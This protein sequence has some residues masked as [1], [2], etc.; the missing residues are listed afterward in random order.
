MVIFASGLNPNEFAA[1]Q[2]RKSRNSESVTRP[3]IWPK[4]SLLASACF[5]FPFHHV[6][7]LYE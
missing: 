1:G 6:N 7:P 2:F 5:R 3:R 4:L